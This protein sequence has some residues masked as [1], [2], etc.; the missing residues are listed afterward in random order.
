MANIEI[1]SQVKKP[2]SG[3]YPEE[4]F[5]STQVYN[6]MVEIIKPMIAA[7]TGSPGD[8]DAAFARYA[9]ASYLT[10]SPPN[11]DLGSNVNCFG[12]RLQVTSDVLIYSERGASYSPKDFESRY[13]H[14]PGIF[15]V[16]NGNNSKVGTMYGILEDGLGRAGGWTGWDSTRDIVAYAFASFL[17]NFEALLGYFKSR[18]ILPSSKAWVLPN[19]VYNK[20]IV[21]RERS[22]NAKI[23]KPAV[24]VPPAT[25]KYAFFLPNPLMVLDIGT[26]TP[27]DTEV[28][29]ELWDGNKNNLI[30]PKKITFPAGEYETRMLFA[31]PP[32]VVFTQGYFN[33]NPINSPMT[34][35]YIRVILPPGGK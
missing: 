12:S 33:I 18:P 15:M 35:S 3:K 30:N 34:V 31:A 25:Y 17:H 26:K 21:A 32:P 9:I 20:D 8:I 23:V 28:Y 19:L 4:V 13:G 14:K 24:A 22:W 5:N 27:I 11:L 10:N 6:S 2:T 7:G 16:K 29:I 1:L